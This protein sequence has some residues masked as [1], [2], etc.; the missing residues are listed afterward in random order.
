VNLLL[1]KLPRRVVR[2]V[3]PQEK[4]HDLELRELFLKE[5]EIPFISDTADIAK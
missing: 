1:D 3:V 2:F 4:K 5:E